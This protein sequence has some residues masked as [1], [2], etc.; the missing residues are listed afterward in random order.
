MRLDVLKAILIVVTFSA[1]A[2]A[3]AQDPT[4]LYVFQIQLSGDGTYMVSNPKF[5][6]GFNPGGYTNQ[7]WFTAEGD[8]LVSVRMKGEEQ[9]DVYRLDLKNESFHRVTATRVN[10]Y[11][12]RITPD[13]KALS[14]LRQIEGD[15]M[16][17]QVCQVSIQ[18]GAYTSL[19]PDFR[20]IGYYCWTTQQQLALY[21]IDGE[22]NHLELYN[23]ADRRTRKIASD[24]GRT[25]LLDQTGSIVYVHK[26]DSTYWYLKRY[27]PIRMT[28]DISA[29]TP[30]LSED[31]SLA[32][33]GTYFMGAG[34]VLYSFRPGLDS[35]WKLVG[36]LSQYGIRDIT[37][38]AISPDGRSLVV[39]N[40]KKKA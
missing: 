35:G 13:G 20:N 16:D 40:V 28:I 15:S 34:S 1:G 2:R 31:F 33:D 21:R 27:H 36:D 14:V 39:A 24:V 30:A 38:L 6:S 32:G 7:P 9:T 3:V 18:G 26:F 8:L 12:P 37:R 4:D 10:E 22:R 5:L 23:P 25:L 17:Q 19:T 11:S 29:Q